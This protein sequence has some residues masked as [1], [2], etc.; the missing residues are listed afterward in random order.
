MAITRAVNL[1]ATSGDIADVGGRRIALDS[2]LAARY[3][4]TVGSD[5]TA[6]F[7][8]G[9][10]TL[11]V[12]AIFDPV[13]VFQGILTDL[14]LAEELGAAADLDTAA[15]FGLAPGADPAQVKADLEEVVAG[16][17][18]IQVQ[19]SQTLRQNFA[20][21]V[22]QLLGFVFAM[23]A[24]AV[25][26]AVLSIINT[27]LLSVTERTA[28]IGMLRAIGATRQQVRAHD[29]DRG[30]R[31]G[32]FRGDL[33]RSAGRGLRPADA[34]CD[35]SAGHHRCRGSVGVD[36]GLR[37]RRRRRRCAGRG[38]ACGHRLTGGHP[39]LDRD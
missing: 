20:D 9:R 21:T 10:E 6:E 28:E 3:G 14:A 33:R 15:Y 25:L 24:L 30:H 36:R 12:V 27:L 16:N 13:I 1:S 17:P 4:L 23:L 38:L 32:R 18:S 26:I 11:R 7:R 5:F 2:R 31:S 29:R 37:D 19:D 34:G 39:G 22:N 35:G 8:T